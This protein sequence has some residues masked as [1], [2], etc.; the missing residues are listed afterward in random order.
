MGEMA[1]R[2]D[3]L[4]KSLLDTL[5][6]IPWNTPSLI[7]S[8]DGGMFKLEL[9]EENRKQFFADLEP[10]IRAAECQSSRRE[11]T[12][13]VRERMDPAKVP[14]YS[15]LTRK[16]QTELPRSRTRH[17]AEELRECRAWMTR[18]GINYRTTGQIP[19]DIWKA[20]EDNDVRLLNPGRI[21]MLPALTA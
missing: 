5:N 20:W 13:E 15:T 6:I 19:S 14:T 3:D 2:F 1:V 12:E 7:F 18:N 9:S 21:P 16:E 11:L 17:S 4:D 10:Y 8:V